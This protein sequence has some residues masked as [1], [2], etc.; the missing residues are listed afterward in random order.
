VPKVPDIQEVFRKHLR[1]SRERDKWAQRGLDLLAAGD[2]KG[3]EKAH[4]K[5]QVFD[6]RR[7]ALQPDPNR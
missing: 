5:A 3:A 7:R 1:Y 2:V 6:L 4:K